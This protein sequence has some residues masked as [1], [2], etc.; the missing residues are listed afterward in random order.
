MR[1][2]LEE[3]VV[4]DFDEDGHIIG[5]E[6]LD[7]SDRLSLD[8]LRTIS[9]EDLVTEKHVKLSLPIVPQPISRADKT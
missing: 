6:V 8:E 4:A 3:G 9:Y 7:A 1:E 5:L 2:D